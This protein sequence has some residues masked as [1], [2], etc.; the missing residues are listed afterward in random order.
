MGH[1]EHDRNVGS[2]LPMYVFYRVLN[3]KPTSP[4]YLDK[5]ERLMLHVFPNLVYKNPAKY[6]L[7]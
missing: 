6:Q 4:Y 3:S 2:K 5:A 1:A 7:V